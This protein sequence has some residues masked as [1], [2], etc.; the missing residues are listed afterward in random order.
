MTGVVGQDADVDAG[1]DEADGAARAFAALQA[2]VA[3]LRRAVEGVPAALEETR[4]PDYGPT[5]GALAQE[6]ASVTQNLAAITSHPALKLTP[7][8]HGR[9]AERAGSESLRKAVQALGDETE[10]V[11]RERQ[12]LAGLVGVA[13]DRA[14]QRRALTWTAGVGV[15][16]GLLLFPLLGSSAPGGSYLAAWT[17]RHADRW[18]AGWSLLEAASPDS[19][20]AL[21]A[22]S[23][24]MGAN[25]EALQACAEAARKAGHEQRCAITVP[26]PVR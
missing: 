25:T 9:A 14:G 19:A 2:E 17:T 13:R 24:L 26:A 6:M 18:L 23:R 20:G 8:Q 15:L 22:A 16:L 12:Q 1:G 7:D 5:L 21:A 10:A 3:A 4:A 11:K